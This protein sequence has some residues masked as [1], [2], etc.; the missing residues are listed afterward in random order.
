MYGN[1]GSVLGQ[2]RRPGGS[3]CRGPT[4]RRVTSRCC[5]A[6]DVRLGGITW[7][8]SRSGFL[9]GTGLGGLAGMDLAA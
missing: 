7:L 4:I 3:F 1:G 6:G 2:R 9:D 8:A 5:V